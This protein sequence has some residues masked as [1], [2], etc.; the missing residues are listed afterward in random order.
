M[1]FWQI[2]RVQ[3]QNFIAALLCVSTGNEGCQ[4]FPFDLL[5]ING[6]N[7]YDQC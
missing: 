6:T 7:I 5:N 1:K 3:C 4:Y 2:P